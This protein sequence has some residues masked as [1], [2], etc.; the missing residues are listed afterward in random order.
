VAVKWLR[1]VV[2]A[3]AVV[4]PVS[5]LATA[6]ALRWVGEGFWLTTVGLYLPRVGFAAPLPLIAGALLA[7]RMR[8]LLWTQA[9]SVV[10]IVFPLMGFVF[11]WRPSA[12]PNAPTLRLLSFNV[13]SGH[14]G[15]EAVVDQIDKYSPDIVV[16]QELGGNES[17]ARLLGSRY[18]TVR[19]SGQ[20]VLATRYTVTA[21]V[22]PDPLPYY[23]RL[24]SPRF[25][26]YA[27]DTPLGP[28]A[29]FNVHPIS[30]REGLYAL[31]GEHG[32]RQE[33]GS[34]RLFASSAAPVI[35]INVG[36]RNLQVQALSKAASRETGAVIIAGDTNLPGLSRILGRYLSG[37]EDAFVQAGW[38]FG[39][40][41]PTNKWRPWMRIDRILANDRLR[42]V[43]FEVPHTVVSD[44]RCVVGDL[45]GARP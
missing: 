40:T 13:D 33:I 27:L 23:G 4:Y 44:H 24:R 41:F 43:R 45:Q 34:G 8:R 22:E 6:A 3:L 38:G 7:F 25:I 12:D 1:R 30:P 18:P 35:E 14:G 17:F 19:V 37:Y 5:L 21:T 10:L 42:F 29:L 9:A 39:Y 36:L 32:L 11:P 16:L 26:E 2:Q 20:F 31:R 28:I 15:A